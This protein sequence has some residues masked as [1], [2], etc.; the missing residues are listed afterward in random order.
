[1]L[2]YNCSVD[3]QNLKSTMDLSSLQLTVEN[4]KCS[5]ILIKSSLIKSKESL[6]NSIQV[7]LFKH[8]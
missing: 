6:D 3:S 7:T 5:H 4:K 8:F 1:M 2:T